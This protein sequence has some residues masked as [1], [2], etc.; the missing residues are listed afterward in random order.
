MVL[1]AATYQNG[2]TRFWIALSSTDTQ[3][4]CLEFQSSNTP[5]GGGP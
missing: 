2:T 3:E 1:L 4:S 5:E